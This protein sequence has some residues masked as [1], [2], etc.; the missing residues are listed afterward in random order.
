MFLLIFKPVHLHQIDERSNR[1]KNPKSRDF[2]PRKY[3][4]L[5]DKVKVNKKR[6]SNN[7]ISTK[8]DAMGFT[9]L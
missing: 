6:S 2:R 8:D 7:I 4:Y 3:F 5:Y 1:N 9:Y